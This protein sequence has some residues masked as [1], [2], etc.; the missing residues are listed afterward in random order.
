MQTTKK[1]T[2]A[3]PLNNFFESFEL[4][5]ELLMPLIYIDNPLWN[6][7]DEAGKEDITRQHSA[8]QRPKKIYDG[9][10]ETWTDPQNDNQKVFIG[11]IKA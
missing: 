1:T 10:T 8:K 11:G 9:N 2:T 6:V 7:G 5:S 3:F 4:S